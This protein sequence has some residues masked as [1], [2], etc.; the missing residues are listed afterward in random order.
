MEKKFR[1]LEIEKCTLCNEEI[2]TSKDN[3]VALA[4]Y[5]SKVLWKINFYHNTCLNNLLI[6]NAEI[7]EKNFKRKLGLAMNGLINSIK[8][9]S[10]SYQ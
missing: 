7:I 6:A 5:K 1:H 4:D 10:L 9:K 2:Y 8:D 3:W